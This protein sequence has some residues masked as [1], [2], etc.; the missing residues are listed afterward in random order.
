MQLCA[1]AGD[2][3]PYDPR[4]YVGRRENNKTW[5]TM[6]WIN[7]TTENANQTTKQPI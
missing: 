7:A 2:L 5:G 1:G 4:K 6:I 3:R